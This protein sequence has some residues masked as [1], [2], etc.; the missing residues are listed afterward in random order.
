[1]GPPL[2]ARNKTV[3]GGDSQLS[4]TGHGREYQRAHSDGRRKTTTLDDGRPTIACWCGGAADKIQNGRC[5]TRH[6]CDAF[7]CAVGGCG[8]GARTVIAIAVSSAQALCPRRPRA[9]ETYGFHH[10]IEQYRYQR[11]SRGYRGRYGKKTPLQNR[12]LISILR[13][14]LA[15]RPSSIAG[16]A[17]DPVVLRRLVLP[18]YLHT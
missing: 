10:Y 16:I 9:R 13:H 5:R 11:G 17:H 1:M 4:R 12:F 6:A 3:A 18:I 2:R 8:G 14:R 15:R 7:G